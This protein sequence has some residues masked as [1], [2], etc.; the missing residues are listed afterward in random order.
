MQEPILVNPHRGEP[1]LNLFH[2]GNP[3]A[4]T[5]YALYYRYLLDSYNRKIKRKIALE[6]FVHILSPYN[7]ASLLK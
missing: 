2:G 7:K 6:N 5:L 1:A 4:S 3:V